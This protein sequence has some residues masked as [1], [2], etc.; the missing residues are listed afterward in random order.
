MDPEGKT[1]FSGVEFRLELTMRASCMPSIFQGSG[2][3]LE[4]LSQNCSVPTGVLTILHSLEFRQPKIRNCG[5]LFMALSVIRCEMKSGNRGS[6]IVA[7][8]RRG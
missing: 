2:G 7:K 1:K 8:T 4:V 3:S 5:P 6:V